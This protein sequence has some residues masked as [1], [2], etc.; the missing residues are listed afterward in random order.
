MGQFLENSEVMSSPCWGLGATAS[1]K[2]NGDGLKETLQ[3]NFKLIP[4]QAISQGVQYA[5][6]LC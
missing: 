6:S 4:E 5:V 3:K 2:V 1:K